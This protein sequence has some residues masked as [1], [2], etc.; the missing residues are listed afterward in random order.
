MGLNTSFLLELAMLTVKD[1]PCSFASGNILFQGEPFG[2]KTLKIKSAKQWTGPDPR[3]AP[4]GR[5]WEEDSQEE[6][7]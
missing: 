5:G 6:G 1:G 4:R 2:G 3:I 7:H